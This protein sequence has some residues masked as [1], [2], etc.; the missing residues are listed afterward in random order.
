MTVR[1]MIDLPGPYPGA[2][3]AVTASRIG[4]RA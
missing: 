2:A 3:S 1:E 4:W